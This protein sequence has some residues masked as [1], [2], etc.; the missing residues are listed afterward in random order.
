MHDDDWISMCL[1]KAHIYTHLYRFDAESYKVTFF[2][3]NK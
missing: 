3:E 2:P 1:N